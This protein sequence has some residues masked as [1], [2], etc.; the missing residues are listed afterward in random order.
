MNNP[1]ETVIAALRQAGCKP[2]RS[3]Q[4]WSARCPAHDDRKPSL[5]ISTGDDGRALLKCHA[6]CAFP[7]IVAAIGLK[8]S[9]L[10]ATQADRN[11]RPRP[12]P[13]RTWPSI[14][15]AIADLS[16]SKGVPSSKWIYLA[17]Q[18]EPA[19]IVLRWDKDAGAKDILPLSRIGDAWALTAMPTPRP[20][21][22]LA[23]IADDERV[24]V[25]EGE[26]A[27]DA[28]IVCGMVAT[29]SAGGA[30]GAAKSDW[31]PLAGKDVVI[32]P[33]NDE[34][35]ENYADN[36]VDLVLGAGARSV[37]VAYLA[38]LWP[39]I[40]FGGDMADFIEE[41][42]SR[43]DEDIR[44][45]IESLVSRSQ[46]IRPN[47]P[48]R[49]KP[50]PVDA[51]PEPVRSLVAAG[52]AAIGCEP[53]F[54]ALPM[55]SAL[56]G[57]I[58]N[59]RCIML[60]R[61]WTEPA[62]LWTAIVGE[63]GTQKTP[64]FKLAVKPVRSRQ[65]QLMKEHAEALKTWEEESARHEAAMNA[66][67][68]KASSSDNSEDPP[69]APAKPS[70]QRTWIEDCTTEALAMLLQE[71]PRGLLT[72]R[73]ELSGWFSFGQY[74]N[75]GGADDVARWL[76][77]FDGDALIVDRKTS[78]TIY[79]PRAAVAM[80]GGIQPSV[81]Q[82]LVGQQHRENGLLAR[83]LLA[84]PS[85]RPKQ[86]TEAE[87]DP[88][89]EGDVA[90]LFDRL[91]QLEPDSD[92]DDDP[93]PRPL[94][95]TPEAK[96]AWISFVNEHGVEQ[97]NLVDEEA[98]AWS[99][100]E[101]Y[102]ARLALIIHLVREATD[103]PSL[104]DRDRVDE[105]SIAA[106]VRLSRWFAAEALRVYAVFRETECQRN[107]RILLDRI[108]QK[109]DSITVREW[110]R[111]RSHR[112]ASAAK[113]ELDSF[114]RDGEGH[115]REIPPGP[116]GGRPSLAFFP[117]DPEAPSDNTP[118]SK[119]GVSSGE[120]GAGVPSVLSVSTEAAAAPADVEAT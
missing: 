45:E 90:I 108:R 62:I 117:T 23:A 5:S 80:A 115:W 12:A 52:A 16:R 83:L 66:W 39:G 118:S 1:I 36:V 42:D 40:P 29:T 105:G 2:N 116:R 17:A 84:Y 7:D 8:E 47:S 59:A 15:A 48:P 34:S 110:Q 104:V 75:G 32:L 61:G 88:L 10:F 20:L 98:A 33:D 100:L 24:Y 68:K 41:R 65:H 79:V 99:K 77:M 44:L 25:C 89:L 53:S 6:G 21:Y 54:V 51:I 18:G 113:A 37:R 60:K 114:V 56:A 85:R 101:G 107:Q 55:L 111:M 50:F 13:R 11:A 112:T 87:V 73:N 49:F 4:G 93:I 76:Q 109:G 69:E 91:H 119:P 95:L 9:D 102:A 96:E 103:D 22:N 3:G 70:C 81:L 74:K 92:T 19:G 106:G 27:A 35:G 71:N 46:P 94:R 97:I 58:G 30:C 64:A 38:D 63:S 14:D 26:K 82:R 86:W 67:K 120:A 57:A 72:L 28:A 78:N 43:S 31:S